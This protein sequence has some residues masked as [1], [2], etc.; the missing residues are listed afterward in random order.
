MVIDDDNLLLACCGA[1]GTLLV[2]ALLEG[3][4]RGIAAEGESTGR[5]QAHA[6]ESTLCLQLR[7]RLLRLTNLF[8]DK[9]DIRLE[10]F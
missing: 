8:V 9:V 7:D 6:L 4:G 5:L 3:L 2:D 10:L 1:T